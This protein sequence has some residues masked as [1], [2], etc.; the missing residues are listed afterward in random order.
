MP[1]YEYQCRKCG[2]RLETLQRMSDAPLTK[3]PE[4][5]GKL[6]KLISAPAFQFKGSGWYVT[7][8]AGKKGDKGDKGDRGDRG[9][10]KGDG[11][12]KAAAEGKSEGKSG[13]AEGKGSDAPAGKEAPA[14][15]E[16]AKKATS[17]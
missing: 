14:A 7:D 1:I 2:H 10:S 12:G 17:S 5:R 3:C 6:K 11:N 9:E 13:G 15:K 16:P 4:C 8:Y